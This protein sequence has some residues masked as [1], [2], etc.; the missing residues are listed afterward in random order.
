M[1]VRTFKLN[2]NRSQKT[3][4]IWDRRKDLQGCTLRVNYFEDYPNF[5]IAS[6][7]ILESDNN[8]Q[9][10]KVVFFR[11]SALYSRSGHKLDSPIFFPPCF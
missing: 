2:Q 10:L 9:N 3:D 11:V 1:H 5:M 8:K 4:F 7:S 6:D